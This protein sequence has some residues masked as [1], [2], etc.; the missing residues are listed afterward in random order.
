MTHKNRTIAVLM[1]PTGSG[2]SALALRLAQSR[3]AV[4]INADAMQMVRQ[5][6]IITARPD[7]TEE[8]RAEHALYGVLDAWQ[9]TSVARWIAL[10]VPVIERAWAEGKVP[11][12]VGGTG[13]YIKALREGL[14]SVPP[15]PAALR[16]QLRARYPSAADGA[17]HAAVAS[18]DPYAAARLKPGDTQRL[19]RALEVMEATGKP[20]GWWQAQAAQP[21]FPQAAW[22]HAHLTAPRAELYARL[23]QRFLTMM[24]AGA[25]AEVRGLMALGLPSGTPILRAHGV[26]E[27]IAHLRGDMPLAEA[28]AKAQQHTR[29]YAKRQITWLRRQLGTES[30]ALEAGDDTAFDAWFRLINNNL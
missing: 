15:I 23:D 20:L 14:A 19:L 26:P 10:A 13:M 21:A 11:L 16:A 17:L 12:L 1:G 18:V 2:K 4:I 22:R 24:E 5:L 9:P 30:L 29:N 3:P 28:I 8:A 25:L 6:R 7:A 27:L